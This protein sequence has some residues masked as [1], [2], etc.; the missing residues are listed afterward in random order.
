[1]PAWGCSSF[2]NNLTIFCTSHGRSALDCGKYK[3]IKKLGHWNLG[4]QLIFGVEL[5][6]N[7]ADLISQ[8]RVKKDFSHLRNILTKFRQ[9]VITIQTL[10]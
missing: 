9:S 4:S 2:V 6:V 5:S 3:F 8:L 1:M 10:F 7:L